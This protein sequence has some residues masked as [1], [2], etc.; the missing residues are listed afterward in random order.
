MAAAQTRPSILPK[1][2]STARSVAN[3]PAWSETSR[4]R[5]AIPGTSD[6]AAM[7]GSSTSQTT[8]RAPASA[9]A[10]ASARPMPFA[11]PVITITSPSASKRARMVRTPSPRA[12]TIRSRAGRHGLRSRPDF[13]R[14]AH[15]AD[16]RSRSPAAWP[17]RALP[18]RRPDP[19]RD[20]ASRRSPVP[21]GH[22]PVARSGRR[23]G[24]D[25]R[26][27]PE[28]NARSDRAPPD[29]R[30]AGGLRRRSRHRTG[31][32]TGDR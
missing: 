8:T 17:R 24:S 29:R 23:P 16:R 30:R 2:R 10:H 21:P 27:S 13:S 25:R 6:R 31:R 7:A 22:G 18:A 1:S 19:R 15:R 3:V 4:R 28:R 26:R 5:V 9:A 11:P 14:S 20:R 32:R 12:E